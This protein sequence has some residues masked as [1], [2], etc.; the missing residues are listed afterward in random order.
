M[1]I[2]PAE[3]ADAEAVA[4]LHVDAWRTAYRGLVPDSFLESLD[5]NRRAQRFRESL[6]QKDEETYLVELE[7]VVLGFVTLGA[8][9]DEDVDPEVV[10]EIWGI[11]L[12]P[13]H[14][15]KG[16]GRQLCRFGERILH[17]RGFQEITLWVFTGNEQARRF[18]EA[19][20]YRAD[21]ATKILNPGAPLETV[22]YRRALG[23]A[24]PAFPEDN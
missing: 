2:R 16:I 4:R 7:G 6:A 21:G 5:W 1:Q 11:Y 8:C 24:E 14:W 3:P 15:R 23:D 19:M 9:R 18:Y 10:G 12:A 17:S 13:Q 22:R 20:G